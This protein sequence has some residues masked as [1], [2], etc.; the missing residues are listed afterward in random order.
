MM[1]NANPDRRAG[2]LIAWGSEPSPDELD[3][4]EERALPMLVELELNEAEQRG[5]YA[6]QGRPDQ[7][8]ARRCEQ[9]HDLRVAHA[10]EHDQ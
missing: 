2:A 1:A 8:R 7:W 4:L 9:R 3:S 10:A 6:T 5:Y